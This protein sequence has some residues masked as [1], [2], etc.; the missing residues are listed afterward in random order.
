[1]G[2]TKKRLAIFKKLKETNSICFLQ[3]THCVDKAES[4]WNSE[5]GPKIY[6]S[7]GLSNS[8]G[9]AILFPPCLDY[10]VCDTV[11]DEDGRVVLLKVKIQNSMYI[12]CN[13]Y[14]PTQD[15]KNDQNNFIVKVKNML[16][17]YVNENIILSGDF[18]VCMNPQL[19][20]QDGMS[21]RGDNVNYR[22]EVKALLQSMN[23]TDCFR[24]LFPTLRRYTWHS[25]GK[26]SRI[27]FHFISE[28]LLNDLFS[29]NITP[30]LHSDHSI[31]KIEI[32]NDSQK[33]SRGIWKM[34]IE[35]LHDKEYVKNIKDIIA[36]CKLEHN[37][38][39]DKAVVWEIIKFEIRQFTLPYCVKRKKDRQA[40]KKSL[41]QD[42]IDLQLK[43]DSAPSED[44]ILAYQTS[45]REL[46]YFEKSEINGQIFR[47]KIKW[48]E[49]GEKNTKF[50]L[51][52]EK[53]N[54]KNKTITA[55]EIDNTIIKESNKI[56]FEQR[57]FYKTLYSEKL[58]KNDPSYTENLEQFLENNE[59]KKLNE[60]QKEFCD[61]PILQDEILKS[62]KKLS[63]CKTPGSDGLP[64][65]WYKL[66]WSDIKD[67]LTESIQYSFEKGEL[68][69]EQKRG[70]ITL[71]PKKSKNRLHLKNWRPISLLNTDY[72]IIAKILASRLQEVL[73]SI[74]HSDQ[75]G[76]LK[77]R[78]IGQN[79]RTLEDVSFFTKHEDIP[80]ILLSIDFEKAFDS[81]NWNFLYKTL[82]H[83]NFGQNFVHYIKTMYNNIE[84]TI[85]NNGS[86]GGYFKL[87]RG[88]RQGCP[89]SAYLFITALEMLACK[90]RN[91]KN[92]KGIKVDNKIIKISLLAD[93]ITLILSDLSSVKQSI[94]VLKCFARCSGLKINVDKTQAKY[95]GKLTT[96]DYFPH[97]LSWIKT[98]IET[99]G[100][101]IVDNDQSNYIHNFQQRIAN[102]KSLL[103]IWKQRKLS[104]KGKVTVLNNLALAPLIYVSSVTNTPDRAIR[105]INNIIQNFMWNGSTSKIS[106]KTL[107]Q[108]IPNGGL[109]LC[110]F[111][112]KVLS[113]KLSWIKRLCHDNDSTWTIIPKFYFGCEN[114]SLLFSAYNTL[115]RNQQIPAFYKDIHTAF[116]KYFRHAPNNIN[117]ILGQS[118]WFNKL[119]NINFDK[120]L[121]KQWHGKGIMQLKDILNEQ[122][123]FMNHEDLIQ[124]YNIST[125]F[126]HTL[127]IH[128]SIPIQWKQILKKHTLMPKNIPPNDTIHIQNK[129]IQIQ[130]TICKMFYWHIIHKDKH[131]P[132]AIY[133]WSETFP[134]FNTRIWDSIFTLPYITLRHTRLQTL[135]YKILHRNIA[136]NKWLYNIKIATTDI[137]DYCSKC[138]DIPHFFYHCPNTKEFWKFTLKWIESIINIK[139]RDT[140][141][142]EE[143]IIFGIP[144][145][146]P[147]PKE[148]I[149]V[150]NYCILYAKHYIYIKKMNKINTFDLYSLKIQIKEALE[151]ERKICQRNNEISKFNKFDVLLS[152]LL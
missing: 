117:E 30:G 125:S 114:L 152:Q 97:G 37:N 44:N 145:T 102:L 73:P 52:L 18:N 137:C 33:R 129:H 151:I 4:G 122:C 109:K 89:L 5:W 39:E 58:N 56:A 45:K 85:L 32:G 118:L 108:D 135:Q 144:L 68:S 77:G 71:I 120:N 107:I 1:L 123:E 104:L 13:I 140:N 23:L 2:Q 28:H 119:I 19:D 143:C 21:T 148:M 113:L 105:E 88:V 59:T 142:T 147:S 42:L 9:V 10:E 76:Y 34:N 131:T 20:K 65:E 101:V 31:L 25:R 74:I 103:N 27:D 72:K 48:A 38:M 95:I 62:I 26:S 49:Q 80:G 139:I 136:C 12:L 128:S 134:G 15:H 78:Y 87:E 24:D 127:Q 126:I 112:M 138:D 61:K 16:A 96:Y 70:I 11:R 110:H 106:Q 67:I 3:E 124:K 69:V 86:T 115:H 54:F 8:A 53:R 55:L 94:H 111:E 29:Y 141:F 130:N 83:L 150:Y 91:D 132:T 149:S 40:F 43:M 17:P 57:K 116:M 84:S 50:F 47:S 22:N 41:E 60:T 133:K 36:K 7:N 46:E 51:S 81:L 64:A 93:D 75:S 63:N 82:Y 79:I 66:F 146:Y 99:L 35:L 98:P 14:A 90:L 100:I 6:F 92:I 121:V